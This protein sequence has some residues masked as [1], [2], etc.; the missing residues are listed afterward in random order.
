MT[1]KPDD[2]KILDDIVAGVEDIRVA[3]IE[4]LQKTQAKFGYLSQDHLIYLAERLG[5]T[6]TDL[7]G[8]ATFYAQFTLTP[9]G[10]HLIQICEG[11]ACHVKSQGRIREHLRDLLEIDVGQTTKDKRF[12]LKSVRCLGCCGLSPVI[13]VDEETFGRVDPSQ[14]EGILKKFV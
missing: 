2:K 4:V 7:Y 13:M 11:T 8:I 6:M 9:P 1:M 12:S 10:K 5:T 3:K 14:I